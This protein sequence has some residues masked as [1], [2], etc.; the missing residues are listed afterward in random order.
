MASRLSS[1]VV[2]R[3]GGRTTRPRDVEA[4][5][6]GAS[7]P[8]GASDGSLARVLPFVLVAAIGAFL[9]GYHVGVVNGALAPLSAELGLAS[10]ATQGAVVS[11]V[12]AAACA[13]SFAGGPLADA[14]GRRGALRAAALPLGLGALACA[15]AQGAGLLLFGRALCGVGLGVASAVVPLYIAEIAPPQ[16]RGVLGSVNQLS[17]CIG[18]LAALLA[19]LPLATV[20]GF[21]RAMFGASAAPAAALFVLAGAIPESP[22]WLARAGR[23]GEAASVATQL[24]GDAAP[25]PTADDGEAKAAPAAWAELFSAPYARATIIAAGLFVVQQFAGVNA[26]IYFSSAVFR[27]A[28]LTNDTLASALVGAV[29]VAGTAAAA[30]ALDRSGRRPLLV[31]S[32]TGMGVA[33]ALLAAALSIPALEPV[34]GPLSLIGTLA[35]IA[36]FASGAGP[37]PSMLVAELYPPRLRGRAQSLAMGTHWVCNFAIGQCFLSAVAAV[38]VGG[39]YAAFAAV[40]AA[41]A[42]FVALRLPETRGRSYEE[43]AAALAA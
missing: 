12:L 22:A 39:V 6:A 23:G 38:G 20:P 21:W 4:G 5:S 28:G 31:A 3:A 34:A 13:G 40:C 24:W 25:P 11:S 41:G 43:V 30:R 9:F 19:G 33:M 7:A 37:V 18:I 32:F 35:Y 16:H 29:N 8:E 15:A 14:T 27:E 26:V 1:G 2:Q 17:I 36:A 42:A 10:V